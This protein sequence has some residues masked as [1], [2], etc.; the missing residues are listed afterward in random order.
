MV[1]RSFGLSGAEQ[2]KGGRRDGLRAM[3]WGGVGRVGDGG[4]FSHFWHFWGVDPENVEAKAHRLCQVSC[5]P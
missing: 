2:G 4:V 3:G 5:F 1:S